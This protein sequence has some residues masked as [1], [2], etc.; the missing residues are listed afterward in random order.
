MLKTSG[1]VDVLLIVQF[2]SNSLGT[3]VFIEWI[4]DF[5]WN[6][7]MDG[8]AHTE[9]LCKW[10]EFDETNNIKDKLFARRDIFG[11]VQRNMCKKDE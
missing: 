10:I 8:S 9:G 7:Q 6:G 5:G 11:I 4:I 3:R 1:C 2:Q